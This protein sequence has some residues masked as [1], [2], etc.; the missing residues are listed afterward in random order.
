MTNQLFNHELIF[1]LFE[2]RVREIQEFL[3]WYHFYLSTTF[4][5]KIF[6][7]WKWSFKK[8]S[9]KQ[10]NKYTQANIITYFRFGLFLDGVENW[11]LKY[12]DESHFESSSLQRK[13]GISPRGEKCIAIDR[14]LKKES[15]SVTLLTSMNEEDPYHIFLDMRKESN[16]ACDFFQTI[17]KFISIGKILILTQY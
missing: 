3:T 11:K 16:T 6:K 15:F 2:I 13:K 9:K 5:K 7:Q 17:K 8:A 1:L 4:I 10:V 12:L 14:E